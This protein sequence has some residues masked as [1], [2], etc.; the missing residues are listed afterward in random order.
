M[1][2]HRLICAP[3]SGPR[4]ISLTSVSA[5]KTPA[6]WRCV[7][8]SSNSSMK[9]A[10]IPQRRPPFTKGM[11]AS[12]QE[13]TDL[14]QWLRA[15][16]VCTASG[17]ATGGS[18]ALNIWPEALLRL[19]QNISSPWFSLGDRGLA[20]VW[21]G[22]TLIFIFLF[23]ASGL[24]HVDVAFNCAATMSGRHVSALLKRVGMQ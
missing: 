20:K 10:D 13:P 16:H 17:N 18:A 1:T 24:Q 6:A 21:Q 12:I 14:R 7:E 23:P 22:D 4:C 11:P 19:S 5:S 9:A 8:T 3:S 2:W 15:I